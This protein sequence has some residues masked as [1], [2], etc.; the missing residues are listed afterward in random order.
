MPRPRGPGGP[1]RPGGFGGPRDPEGR[2]ASADRD[3]E[4]PE[5]RVRE[6]SA[7]SEDPEVRAFIVRLRPLRRRT[8]HTGRT[9]TGTDRAACRD[10]CSML[11]ALPA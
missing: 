5:D 9:D 4:A 10:A 6:A 2:E 7:I 1:G 11:Q 8:G 3:R